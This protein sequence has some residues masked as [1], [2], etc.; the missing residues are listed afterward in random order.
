MRR[1]SSTQRETGMGW[2]EAVVVVA[3][4]ATIAGVV[5]ALVWLAAK[6][7][8]GGNTDER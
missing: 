6:A 3:V 5:G 4:L 2:P 8:F 1:A 7:L